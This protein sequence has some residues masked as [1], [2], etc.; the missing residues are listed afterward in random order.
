MTNCRIGLVLFALLLGGCT[1]EASGP[2]MMAPDF[3]LDDLDGNAVSLASLR[4]KTVVIDFWATWCAPC[5]YQPAELNAFLEAYEGDDLVVLGIEVGGAS[6]DEIRE[7][8]EENDAVARYAILR[9]ALESLPHKYGVL[10]YPALVVV[11]PE[12]EIAT[13]HSGVAEAEEV[14]E[15]VKEARSAG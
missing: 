11:S 15:L 6:V 1:A 3:T 5:V 9:D 14:E 7:R 4:G 13:L 10:G 8:G 2:R 12:G